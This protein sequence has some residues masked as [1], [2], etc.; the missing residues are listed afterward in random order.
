M[1]LRHTH[2]SYTPTDYYATTTYTDLKNPGA[3]GRST[4]TA[5]ELTNALTLGDRTK[6]LKKITSYPAF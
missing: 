5:E 3:I 1:I 6:P 4:Q 2:S